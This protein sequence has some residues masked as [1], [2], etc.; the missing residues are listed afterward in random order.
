MTP[1]APNLKRKL[2]L[3]GE[4]A[5]IRGKRIAL[6]M[7]AAGRSER[8]LLDALSEQPKTGTARRDIR[9]GA[10]LMATSPAIPLE[11]RQ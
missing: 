1:P 5:G 7:F 11:V 6:T 9:P 3:G 8:D 4:M 10:A 2:A